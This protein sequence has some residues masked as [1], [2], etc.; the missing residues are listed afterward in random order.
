MQ[1]LIIIHITII[2]I[3]I[4]STKLS[5]KRCLIWKLLSINSVSLYLRV[6]VI[7]SEKRGI[8]STLKRS[9]GSS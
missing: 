3:Y 6:R 4:S 7:E 2:K 5:E 9:C 8:E 1:S